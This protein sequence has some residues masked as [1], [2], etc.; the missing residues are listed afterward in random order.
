MKRIQRIAA[1]LIFTLL[2]SL[3]V[4]ASSDRFDLDN[5]GYRTVVTNGNYDKSARCS[6]V[7]A[8]SFFFLSIPSI[9]LS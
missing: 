3:P 4:L 5:Y 7:P 1:L 8:A 9:S 2:L 6:L